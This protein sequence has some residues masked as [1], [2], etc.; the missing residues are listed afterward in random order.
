MDGISVGVVSNSN[1]NWS[2]QPII[3]YFFKR[4]VGVFDE[5]CYTGTGSARTVQH[6]LGVPPELMIV[7]D[8]IFSR[9]WMVYQLSLGNTHYVSLNETTAALQDASAWN[10]TSPTESQFTLGANGSLNTSNNGHVAYLFV[11]KTG[12]SKVFSYTGNGSSQ[13]IDCGFT[14]GARFVMVKRTD[15]AGDWMISDVTRGIVASS[16][17]RLSLNTTAAE[18]TNDDW[19]DPDGTGSGFIVNQTAASNANVSGASYIGLSFA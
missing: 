4:A 12:I 14:T 5:V 17:P 15:A 16:D 11:S 13:T 2:P 8:R 18:I 7:K 1:I 19:L 10:N 6:G 3:N 9:K